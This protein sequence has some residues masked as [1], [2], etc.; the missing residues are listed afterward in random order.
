MSLQSILADPAWDAPFFKLLANND[1]G[2]ASGHQGGVVIPKE[3][4]PYFP[5]LNPKT[6]P[7]FCAIKN[8]KSR[9]WIHDARSITVHYAKPCIVLSLKLELHRNPKFFLNA[10]PICRISLI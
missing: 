6:Q 9:Y 10:A 3:L 1:T 2:A 7:G 4:R 8:V 5:S